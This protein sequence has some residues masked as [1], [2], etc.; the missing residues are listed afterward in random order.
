MLKAVVFDMDGTLG[1]T[2]PLC[3]ESFARCVEEHTGRRPSEEEVTAHF[4]VSDRGILAGLLGM[5][6]DDPELPVARFAEIY[7]ALHPQYA[8]APFPGAV[9]LL[10][11]LKASGWRL[12]LLTGKE[13]YTALPTLRHFH[14]QEIFEAKLF[15]QPS[16]N[17][18]AERLAELMQLWQLA[19]DE[20]IYIGDAPSDIE[21]SHRA[22]VRIICAAWSPH[23]ETEPSGDTSPDYRLTA[24]CQLEPLLAS[25]RPR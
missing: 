22:G 10:Q 5:A 8:P 21:Q 6:A 23:V 17:C 16:H 4:S 25:L 2:L 13:A 20:L 3:V 1:D 9:E 19:P 7:D 12:A 15:G 14:M 18:K 24:F 11:R